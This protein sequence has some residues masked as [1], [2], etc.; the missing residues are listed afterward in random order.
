MSWDKTFREP[1]ELPDGRLLVS[2]RDA[3]SYITAL[4]AT[5]IQAR[6]WQTAMHVLIEAADYAG[7]VSFARLG[8]AQALDRRAEKV[9]DPSRKRAHWRNSAAH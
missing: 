7:P 3:G 6:E 4:P 9:F 8:M 1:I 5:E 2:L